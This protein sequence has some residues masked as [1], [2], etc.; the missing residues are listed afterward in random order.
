GHFGKTEA[1]HILEAE[2]GAQLIAGVRPGVSAE[3]L[4]QAIRTG[5]LLEVVAY[6]RVRA[7]D[8]VFMPAG[9]LHALGPG[10]LLY[11][12]QQTSDITYRVFD[13]NRP[14]SAGRALHLEQS[15]RVANPDARGQLQHLPP[16]AAND[17]RTLVTCQYFRLELLVAETEALEL[18]THGE[19]FHA[20]TVI[21]GAAEVAAGSERLK[22]GRF[23][24]VVVP[25]E[26]GAYRLEP[27]GV[28]RV[29]NASVPGS[30]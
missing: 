28:F 20:L 3:A 14:A 7:G 19:S 2:A 24:S 25:A 16:L 15:A 1:W 27:S 12:V 4:A 21:E 13:W 5:A 8:T 6:H 9:T 18:D 17:R 11:E 26:I 30:A 22:L 10:L 29:L 23:E